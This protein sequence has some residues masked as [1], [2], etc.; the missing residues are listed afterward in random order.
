MKWKVQIENENHQQ[1]LPDLFV[2]IE[3]CL[4]LNLLDVALNLESL[5]L[6]QYDMKWN[7]LPSTGT[8]L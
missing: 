3:P 8:D 2:L 5:F 6:S 7:L 4:Y 1:L